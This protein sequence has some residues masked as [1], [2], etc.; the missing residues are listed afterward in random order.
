MHSFQVTSFVDASQIYGNSAP[1]ADSQRTFRG[2]RIQNHRLDNQNPPDPPAGDICT[3]GAI[4][5]RCF[6]PGDGRASEQPALTSFHII[7]VRKHNQLANLLERANPHWSDEK[8]Y[9]ETRR[10]VAA[11]MQH[12]TYREFL[13]IVL[14]QEVMTLFDLDLLPKGYYA[15]YDPT[16]N[17]SAANSF[18]AAAF[19]FGHSL[20][21]R[22]FVRF[23]PFHRPLFNS[24]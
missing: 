13:P 17:P 2:G 24:K 5:A 8:I 14:G 4:T 12:I 20:V 3:D 9:Q 7:W 23:D 6:R 15:G 11:T 19:R 22:S 16:V 18:T 1:Q 10:I 21:Q